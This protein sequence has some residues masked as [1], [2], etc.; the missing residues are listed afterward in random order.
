ML[1]KLAFI[2]DKPW[3]FFFKRT[4]VPRNF[5]TVPL[6]FV[7]NVAIG[8]GTGA[9]IGAING[10]RFA[11]YRN[12]PIT[13]WGEPLK[14]TK[15]PISRKKAALIGASIGSIAGAVIAG[16]GANRAI[17]RYRQTKAAQRAQ[18]YQ[19]A[20]QQGENFGRKIQ[21]NEARFDNPF[22][23]KGFKTK[24]EAKA[25][26]RDLARRLHPDMPSGNKVGFQ[27]LQEDWQDYQPYFEKLSYWR[28]K[29]KT[30]DSLIKEAEQAIV[31]EANDRLI[32]EL[33]PNIEKNAGI[34]G[35]LKRDI[36]SFFPI[37]PEAKSKS[38]FP[39]FPVVKDVKKTKV[40]MKPRA[41]SKTK[42]SGKR[43]ENIKTFGVPVLSAI[44]GGLIVSGLN[45]KKKETSYV[46]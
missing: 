43:I 1:I 15:E 27:N 36:K 2:R 37:F 7:K 31:K 6:P 40:G 34:V 3:I 13:V 20:K 32:A 21:K 28:P 12:N 29:M 33:V 5:K 42:Q 35:L 30:V 16:G 22:L 46:A 39:I 10:T 4:S 41:I 9:M 8:A 26:Y 17:G 24:K 25:H 14:K 45:K 38:F 18:N 23:I 19:W 44:G 11:E